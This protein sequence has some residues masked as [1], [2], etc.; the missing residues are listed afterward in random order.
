MDDHSSRLGDRGR[1]STENH[2]FL[3][4]VS[5]TPMSQ[6]TSIQVRVLQSRLERI[7]F[8]HPVTAGQMSDGT[9]RINAAG[10][11]HVRTSD[12]MD[13]LLND[14]DDLDLDLQPNELFD[15]MVRLL[16]GHYN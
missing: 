3:P 16:D 4:C 10:S 13:T 11:Y 7:D 6:P 1:Y 9:I 12:E 15:S 2:Q 5:H 8:G 14:M